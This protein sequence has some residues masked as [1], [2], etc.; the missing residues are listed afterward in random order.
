MLY[1]GECYELMI[2]FKA[3][4]DLVVASSASN[5]IKK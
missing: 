5:L 3:I 4:C 2:I 1:W